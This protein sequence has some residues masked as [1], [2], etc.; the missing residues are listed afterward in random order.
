MNQRH[1]SKIPL[2][3]LQ[4]L[5]TLLIFAAIM[6]GLDFFNVIQIPYFSL[7]KAVETVRQNLPKIKRLRMANNATYQ[8]L[9]NEGANRVYIGDF[10]KALEAYKKASE[11]EPYEIVPYEKIGDVYFLQKEYNS[12]LQNFEYCESKNPANNTFKIKSVRSLL[13]LRKIIDAKAKLKTINEET[14]S[15]LYY[16]GLIAA[17]LNE[18]SLAKELLERILSSTSNEEMKSNVQKILT[19]YRDFELAKDGR[20]EFLQ[21][22]LAQAFD[23]IEEYGMAIELAFGAIK[24]KHDYR[25]AW[26]VLGHAFLNENRWLDSEDAF[27]KAIELDSGHPASYFFRGIAMRRLKKTTEAIRDFEQALKLGWQPKILAKENLADI[28]FDLKDFNKAFP[29]YKE[30]VEMDPSDIKQFTRPIALAINHLKQPGQALD[31]ANKAYAAHPDTAMGHNLLGWAFMANNDL[32]NADK[33]LNAALK[34]DPQLAAAYLNLGQ[35]MEQKGDINKA[36]LYYEQ[37]VKMAQKSYDQ[38]I[39]DTARQKYDILKI[40]LENT[41]PPPAGNPTDLQNSTLNTAP[42]APQVEYKRIPSLNLL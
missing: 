34:T 35:L 40:Q 16:Q 20:I 26:I 8:D 37:A 6:L 17:F 3:I 19:V 12:A 13:G 10:D 18:Q 29:L 21:T 39:S 23:Q 42:L 15:S 32:D 38:S 1:Q 41:P 22:M 24:I 30:I 33:H 7:E 5:G 25:D 36:V 31:L 14:D 11:L 4:I 28:Y 2:R 9:I 27:K